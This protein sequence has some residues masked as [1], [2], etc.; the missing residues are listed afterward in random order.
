MHKTASIRSFR[1]ASIPTINPD[2]IIGVRTPRL[3]SIAKELVRLGEAETFMQALPHR[4]FEENQLH[5]FI[6]S[7][8]R[9]FESCIDGVDV[10]LP[11]VDN[12]ATCDQMSPKVFGKQKQNLLPHIEQW[13]CSDHTYTVRFGIGMLMRHYLDEFCI[14]ISRTGRKAAFGG[15]LYKHD[16]CMVFR[17]GT[18]QAV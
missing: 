8:D 12:W 5:A 2:S 11:Y 6:L 7:L 10:F 1:Q 14:R 13:L 4:Y 9:N 15:I 17:D 16:G 3:R 18:G